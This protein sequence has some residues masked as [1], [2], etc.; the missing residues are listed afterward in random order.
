M[1]QQ[2]S[3]KRTGKDVE[4]GSHGLIQCTYP[5]SCLVGLKET[6]KN[7]SQDHY[8][9]GQD[10]NQPPPKEKSQALP[11]EPTCS[12]M[13]FYDLI[14]GRKQWVELNYMNNF[15]S[16]NLDCLLE[17]C[18]EVTPQEEILNQHIYSDVTWRLHENAH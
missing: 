16:S 2:F 13:T 12:V 8:C 1:T 15:Q 17:L 9:S 18:P 7:F 11:H 14:L 5:G 3:E 4:G 10:S 6:T